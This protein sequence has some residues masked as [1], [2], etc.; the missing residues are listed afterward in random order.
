MTDIHPL[1][2]LHDF[3]PTPPEGTRALMSVERFDGTI[4]EPA[5][6]DGAI[7]KVLVRAGYR[8]VSTDLID[9]GYGDGGINFLAET[10]PRAKHIITNPPY[11]R[12]LAD[13]FIRHALR[14]TEATGGSVAMLLD[15][16]GLAHPSRTSLY[17][18]NPP[19]NVYLL[20]ELICAPRG[21]TFPTFEAQ[22][23][24]AWLVW[25]PHHVGRPALW[26]IS[27]ARFKSA[28]TAGGRP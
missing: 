20:D 4:W 14:L 10:A 7:S 28:L 17:V 22:N 8:V 19:A 15:L 25:K 26:W 2:E 24:F 11:G 9:R 6:G 3:Y 13:H 16:A 18:A 27:T 23:R 12:G 5:C 1:R 21:R